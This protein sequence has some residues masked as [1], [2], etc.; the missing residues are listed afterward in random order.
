MQD[1]PSPDSIYRCNRCGIES[2]EPTCFLDGEM[3]APRGL[4]VTCITCNQS[5]GSSRGLR[6]VA[7][8]FGAIALPVMFLLALEPNAKRQ[9]V[10]VIL[11]AFVMQPLIVVLHELG[12]FLTARLLGLQASLITLGAGYK[13][14]SGRI[15]G[16]PLRVHGWPLL[17]MTYLG[18]T[19]LHWLRLRVWL[20][21][22][23][24]PVTNVLLIAVAVVLWTPLERLVGPDIIILWILFNGILAL[25]NLLPRSFSID[26]QRHRTD[27]MQLLQ[28]PFKKTAEL[29]AY[30]SSHATV[31]ALVLWEDGDYAGARNAC[32]EA[33]QRLPD[34]PVI[35]TILSACEITLGDYDAA[36]VVLKPL[37]DV[38]TKVPPH[39]RAAAANNSALALW[40]GDLHSPRAE[41]STARADAL[42][43]RAY[44]M[45]PCVLPYRSTRALLLAATDR[46]E[47]ALTLLGYCNYDRASKAERGDQEAARAFALRHLDRRQEA[48]QALAAA[49]QL[50][51][52]RRY[53]LMRLGLL[54]T[55]E[56]NESA[57]S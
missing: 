34:N 48:D 44:E 1:R 8:L 43:N 36:Q 32:L 13:L 26:G 47:E 42:S 2:R 39:V 19:S 11:A 53:W 4:A 3:R 28:I 16:V 37:L 23:I 55:P 35:I 24:G 40:F 57:P 54:P 21:V 9:I 50:N 17:G 22:L 29:A 27:G 12:H 10:A 6:F 46:A 5:H 31:T 51:T 7:G 30:L 20:T 52:T 15:L 41:L 14:W 38:T 33:L 18:T 56:A 25:G 45:Y 49:L